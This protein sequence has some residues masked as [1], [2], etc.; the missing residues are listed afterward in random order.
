[1][2][3]GFSIK[4]SFNEDVAPLRKFIKIKNYNTTTGKTLS[5][6]VIKIQSLRKIGL[7]LMNKLFFEFLNF[8]R[9]RIDLS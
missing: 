4:V 3:F 8:R 7:I 9:K 2:R 1:M 5:K 6:L